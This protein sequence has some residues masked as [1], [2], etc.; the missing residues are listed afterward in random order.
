MLNSNYIGSEVYQARMYS[1]DLLDEL[2]ALKSQGEDTCSC[3]RKYIVLIRWI[4]ILERY[5]LLNYEDGQ[6]IDPA[7]TLCLTDNEVNELVAKLRLMRGGNAYIQGDWLL[8][9]GFWSDAGFWRDS[10]TWNDTVPIV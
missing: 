9:T 10:A 7:P 1:M 8:I 5:L 4:E 3:T 2:V 6:P